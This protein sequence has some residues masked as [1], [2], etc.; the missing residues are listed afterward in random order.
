MAQNAFSRAYH[1][2]LFHSFIHSPTAILSAFVAMAIIVG[3]VAALAAV[4]RL[5]QPACPGGKHM[6]H[7]PAVVERTPLLQQQR[8]EGGAPD[9]FASSASRG[10]ISVLTRSG[11]SGPGWR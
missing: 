4:E 7:G 10:R 3:A 1:S 9:H 2:D 6:A 11:V 5:L 8:R